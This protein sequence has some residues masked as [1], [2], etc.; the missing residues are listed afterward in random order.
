MGTVPEND[1]KSVTSN[2]L[3]KA[4]ICGDFLLDREGLELALCLAP[5]YVS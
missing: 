2:S 4:A 1:T 5:A 3:L